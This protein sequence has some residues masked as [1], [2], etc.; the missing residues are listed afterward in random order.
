MT[1]WVTET[2]ILHL[3]KDTIPYEEVLGLLKQNNPQM[4]CTIEC[5][6]LEKGKEILCLSETVKRKW[7]L[8]KNKKW[9]IPPECAIFKYDL[10]LA[11]F[12]RLGLSLMVK[13]V[14]YTF[15]MDLSR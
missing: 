6:S 13:A 7:Y 14:W 10:G 9:H 2:V 8:I 4:D 11:N 1:I 5:S 15:C 12:V 3:E